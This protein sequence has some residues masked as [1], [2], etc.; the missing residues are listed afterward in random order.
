M[1]VYI[2]GYAYDKHGE[3]KLEGVLATSADEAAE[4]IKARS[5]RIYIWD[6]HKKTAYPKRDVIDF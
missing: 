6:V 1:D 5:P 3:M 4:I 2:V